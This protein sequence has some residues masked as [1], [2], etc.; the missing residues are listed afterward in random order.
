[1]NEHYK[2]AMDFHRLADRQV[3]ARDSERAA[4]CALAAQTHA[5]LYIGQQLEAIAVGLKP[6]PSVGLVEMTGDT[7]A[8]C[9]AR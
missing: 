4:Q 6:R 5:L 9:E 2:N 3:D 8:P 7:H 1:M